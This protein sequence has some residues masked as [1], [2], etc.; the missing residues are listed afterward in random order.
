VTTTNG[1]GK[2]SMVAQKKSVYGVGGHP[3]LR[4]F[5]PLMFFFLGGWSEQPMA[6]LLALSHSFSHS[7]THTRP[8]SLTTWKACITTRDRGRRDT[9]GGVHFFCFSLSLSH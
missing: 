9:N 1:G 8:L 7:H 4:F 6:P 3:H 5:F 2:F